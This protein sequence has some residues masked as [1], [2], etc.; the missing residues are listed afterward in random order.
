MSLRALIVTVLFVTHSVYAEGGK[1]KLDRKEG[2]KKC[3][4][5]RN[6]TSCLFVAMD[7]DLALNDE[8]AAFFAQKA[9]DF[10]DTDG[11]T[12]AAEIYTRNNLNDKAIA[13]LNKIKQKKARSH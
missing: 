7:Y 13:A 3:L 2:E 4:Q 5:D 1:A 8:M 10:G 9:C 12:T 11:C 6:T